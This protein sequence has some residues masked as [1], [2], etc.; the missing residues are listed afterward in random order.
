MQFLGHSTVRIDLPGRVILTD[1]VLTARV[2]PLRRVCA[3]LRRVDW[4]GVD[5]VLI[6]HL[7]GD[8]L[9]LPSLRQLGTDVRIV[10]PRGAGP[11]LT[12][13]GFTNVEEISPGESITDA[14]L[15]LTAIRA[16]HAAHR[17]GPRLHVGPS[18]P[19]IGYLIK[20]NGTRTYYAGDTDLVHEMT[21][22][23]EQAA[24]LDVALLPVW[25]WGP[26]IGPGHLDPQRAATAARLLAPRFAVPVHWGTLAVPGLCR[27]PGGVG[28]HMR[29]LLAEPPRQFAAAVSRLGL[30]TT[31]AIAEPGAR[32]ALAP[33]G[34]RSDR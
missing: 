21:E 27:V 2:G 19:P 25:G 1:P 5:T 34:P 7:H 17:W 3:P 10:V 23:G 32:V 30:D 24:R 15:E 11:W 20:A 18:A 14:G 16:D 9:H 4:A 31:V 26:N 28:S 29:A 13:H 8:H 33:A 6:S 22:I 12:G